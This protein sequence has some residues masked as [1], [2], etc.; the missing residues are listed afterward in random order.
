MKQNF[1]LRSNF[2]AF[3]ATALTNDDFPHLRGDISVTL[4]P[5]LKLVSSLSISFV[6]LVNSEPS[7]RWPK[8]NGII[9]RSSF[10]AISV[11]YIK[12]R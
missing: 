11:V 9:P 4:I 2:A 6:R 12:G 1:S 8:M 5:D 10:F 3:S 7:A